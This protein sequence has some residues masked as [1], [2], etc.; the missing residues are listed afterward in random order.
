MVHEFDKTCS[1]A[2]L[3]IEFISD[4]NQLCVS[5][6]N[7][8]FIFFDCA[9]KESNG[10]FKVGTSL[11]LRSTQKCLCYVPRKRLLMSGGTD[12]C[13]F[14]WNIDKICQN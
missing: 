4:K 10:S 3:A 12:G 8:S 2:I 13:V 1:D 11:K 7:R 9:K 5:L 6:S 14:A